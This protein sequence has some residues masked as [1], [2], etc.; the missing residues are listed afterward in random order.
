MS[1]AKISD[2]A[3]SL[4]KHRNTIRKYIKIA[5]IEADEH[6]R[7]SVDEVRAAIV[8]RERERGSDGS[9]ALTE[10]RIREL[11]ARA[12][13]LERENQVAEEDLISREEH[14]RI[15]VASHAEVANR[16]RNMPTEL[17]GE[18]ASEPS[19]KACWKILDKWRLEVAKD[20]AENLNA[21]L[22]NPISN[23]G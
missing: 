23:G 6:G 1:Y 15:Y 13:K 18:L 20:L 11:N 4:G 21:R 22:R 5:E 10:A 19:A 7:Y 12:D 3:K 14:A 9:T 17:S 2:I 8:Q 16:L